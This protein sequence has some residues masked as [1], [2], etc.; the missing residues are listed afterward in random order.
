MLLAEEFSALQRVPL[1]PEASHS[2]ALPGLRGFTWV[3]LHQKGCG[4]HGREIPDPR[5]VRHN[6][7]QI[8][9]HSTAHASY[10][11]ALRHHPKHRTHWP[12]WR[13]AKVGV[14]SECSHHIGP[15]VERD[16]KGPFCLQL[17][18]MSWPFCLHLSIPC[19]PSKPPEPLL[20]LRSRPSTQFLLQPLP[21]SSPR[22]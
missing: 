13:D 17:V 5:C 22:L 3:F 8:H 7:F 16:R 10:L 21:A 12:R 14:S 20:Q 1:F 19:L 9:S 6:P 4:D 15:K 2:L 18:T 11:W